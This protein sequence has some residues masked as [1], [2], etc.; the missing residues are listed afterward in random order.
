MTTPALFRKE[1]LAERG[2]Q[3]LGSV[4]LAPRLSHRVFAA[5][6]VLSTTA[7]L[8]VF[9]FGEYPRKARIQGWLVPEDG[10]VR[11]FAPQAGVITGIYVREGSEVRKGDRLVS[12]SAELEST[13]LGRTLEEIARKLS[14]RRDSLK[15][16]RRS[17]EL[18]LDQ[19]RRS[20]DARISAL[21][22]ERSSLEGEIALQ[23]ARLALADSSV[24]RKR[25]MQLA[26]VASQEQAQEAEE[27]RLQQASAL[28]AMERDLLAKAREQ[29]ELKSTLEELPLKSQ[30]DIADVERSMA[31]LE[32]E[33]AEVEARREVVVTAPEAGT[34]TAVQVAQGDRPGLRMPLLSVVPAGARLEARMFGSGRAIGFIRGGQRVLLRYKPYPYQKFGHY[35]GVVATVSRSAVSPAELPPELAGLTGLTGGG[36]PVY[37]ITVRLAREDVTAYGKLVPLQPGMEVEADVV[38]ETRRLFEWVLE[39][40]YTLAGAWRR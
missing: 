39:P 9:F 5:C 20:L 1:A 6:A 25:A 19:Q 2:A 33:L 7:I 17:L 30:A 31:A 15:A 11:V 22:L 35:E 32:Q 37:P 10:L 38:I 13:A 3:R 27:S 23:R 18:L 24:A 28:R 8:G 26:G 16:Q 14:A 40:L 21:A 34:V 4:V 29:I 36:E 12:L